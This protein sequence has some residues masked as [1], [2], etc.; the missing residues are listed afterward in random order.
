MNL[1]KFRTIEAVGVLALF[2]FGSVAYAQEPSDLRVLGGT[3]KFDV[4]TNLP[5]LS[6]HGQSNEMT[7][8][9][10][11]RDNG[12]HVE[13]ENVNAR[14]D[15]KTFKTGMSLR[16]EHLRKKVF[17][18]ENGTM[19][20]LQFVG[21]K[22]TCPALSVSRNA[23]CPVSGQLTLRGVAKPFSI[24]LVV[25][26]AGKGYRIS[27]AGVVKLSTF[28]I[29]PPCQLGVC[30]TDEVKLTFEFQAKERPAI[31]AGGF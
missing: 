19:P 29:E 11:L 20:E 12:T 6:V 14:I 26:N 17:S 4:P 30:V 24:N 15:P 9:L 2:V 21:D 10:R 22:I 23:T 28:G 3:V 16:D 13:L 5:V 1:R 18:L 31:H 8:T 7:A 27:A 25:S